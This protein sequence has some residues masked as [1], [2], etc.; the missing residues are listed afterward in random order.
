MHL[1]PIYGW[2]VTRRRAPPRGAAPF[3]TYKMRLL[4]FA[5]MYLYVETLL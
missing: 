3:V 5:V 1:I 4:Y 2:A